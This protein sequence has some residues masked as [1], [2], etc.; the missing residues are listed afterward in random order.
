MVVRFMKKDKDATIPTFGNGDP[1]NA[2]FDF[3]SQ[4]HYNI[5]PKA[6]VIVDTGI[7][8]DGMDIVQQLHDRGRDEKP[9]IQIKSRSGLAFNHSLEASNAGVIDAAYTGN[10]KIKLYNH[11]EVPITISKGDR[12][13]QGILVT[14]PFVHILETASIEETE[15]GANGFGSTGVK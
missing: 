8:W 2:G 9:Y 4:H 5:Y 6:Y 10:I 7:A 3:Y 13:A 12:I 15:R 11:G 1:H 14:L